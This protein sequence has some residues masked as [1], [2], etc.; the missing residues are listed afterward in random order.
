MIF[1]SCIARQVDSV[2]HRPTLITDA[3]NAT[4]RHC[5]RPTR[6]VAIIYYRGKGFFVGMVTYQK[7]DVDG[8]GVFYR[9]A[10]PKDD[11]RR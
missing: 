4:S 7:V 9:E 6:Q 11:S 5:V 8:I 10:G 3:N 1:F 2:R